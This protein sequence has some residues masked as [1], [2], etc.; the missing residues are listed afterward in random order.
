MEQVMAHV[1]SA[2]EMCSMMR[3]SA[4]VVDTAAADAVVEA[5]IG[6]V[7]VENIRCC[8]LLVVAAAEVEAGS[9]DAVA[10]P[11]GE[12]SHAAR[13]RTHHWRIHHPAEELA[14][15]AAARSLDSYVHHSDS[16][17]EE[18]ESRLADAARTVRKRSPSASL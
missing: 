15:R 4:E 9:I 16:T 12:H 2:G 11:R 1:P 8:T 10:R 3:V 5:D 14:A 13:R 7:L 17:S 6:W 18:A